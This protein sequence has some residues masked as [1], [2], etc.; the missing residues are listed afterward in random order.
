M[1]RKA[2]A[3]S[4]M[5][6][7]VHAPSTESFSVFD[8][9]TSVTYLFPMTM[10]KKVSSSSPAQVRRGWMMCVKSVFVVLMQIGEN[11]TYKHY[12]NNR[13]FYY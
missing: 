9:A 7:M 1:S 4:G 10:K 5:L 8:H 11:Y 13:N 6:P 3:A 2:D 12:Q